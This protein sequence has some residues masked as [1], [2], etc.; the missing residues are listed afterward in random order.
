MRR[1]RWADLSTA[2]RIVLVVDVALLIFFIV[3]AAL[4]GEWFV[5]ATLSAASLLLVLLLVK[6]KPREP[7]PSN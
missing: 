3:Q 1:R 7:R 6:T 4:H 5:L 2:R